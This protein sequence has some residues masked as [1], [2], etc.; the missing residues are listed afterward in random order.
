[1]LRNDP[2][3]LL[4]ASPLPERKFIGQDISQEETEAT[5]IHQANPAAILLT[6]RTP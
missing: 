3:V 6:S 1:M 4:S 2:R 5:E